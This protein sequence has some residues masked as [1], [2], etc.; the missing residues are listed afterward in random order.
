MSGRGGQKH[1][2]VSCFDACWQ[3][4][5]LL[6]LGFG[7]STRL[8]MATEGQAQRWWPPAVEVDGTHRLGASVVPGLPVLQA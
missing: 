6:S 1:Q 4:G 5:E 2:S 8:M 3:T 7:L